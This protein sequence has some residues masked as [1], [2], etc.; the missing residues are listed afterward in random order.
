[1]LSLETIK[2]M[3]REAAARAARKGSRPLIL[4]ASDWRAD[5]DYCRRGIFPPHLKGITN[6]APEFVAEL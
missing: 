2:S 4:T 3:N 6:L 1:M 5:L